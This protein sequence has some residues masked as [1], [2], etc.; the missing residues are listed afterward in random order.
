M[1]YI[2][3]DNA[4]SNLR[5]LRKQY[6]ENAKVDLSQKPGFF[7][8][9]TALGGT[10]IA[11]RSS[12][13]L[14]IEKMLSLIDHNLFD[15]ED[16]STPEQFLASH[17]AS[18][19]ALAT[20]LYVRS[21]ISPTYKV[22][23]AQ[24]SDLYHIIDTSLGMFG[25]NTMDDE[26]KLSCFHTAAE[27]M[28]PPEAFEEANARLEKNDL[29]AFSKEEWMAFQAFV[30]EKISHKKPPENILNWPFTSIARPLFGYI[31][32]SAGATIGLMAGHNISSSS[33]LTSTNN[34]I[35]ATVSNG[36]ILLGIGSTLGT[37]FIAPILATK[38][39]DTFLQIFLARSMHYVLSIAGEGVG[40]AIG[41][42]LDLAYQ[43]LCKSLNSIYELLGDQHPGL[44]G[45]RIADGKLVTNGIV[46]ESAENID[47]S[48][49]SKVQKAEAIMVKSDGSFKVGGKAFNVD[50]FLP[51]VINEL[52]QKLDVKADINPRPV[53]EPQPVVA[54]I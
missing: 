5:D 52:K 6:E 42:P 45:L 39:L 9:P 15:K 1:R 47:P 22:R 43:L 18:K 48:T 10:D 24:N 44:S 7:G 2:L 14:F 53:Q 25:A 23:S 50:D 31:G 3:P 16:I 12:Q 33:P 34:Y 26:D 4:I 36:I 27:L 35:A 38:L 54:A 21:Q 17:R 29:S 20:C 40:M 32:S 49:L 8:V 37:P 41:L 11:T 46:L 51:S 19:L 28:K 13:I 30:H